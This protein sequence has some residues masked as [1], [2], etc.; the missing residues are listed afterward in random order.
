MTATV[1]STTVPTVIIPALVTAVIPAITVSFLI[2]RNILAFVPVV[3]DKEDPLAAGVVFAT[4]LAPMF[5]VAWGY[6]QIDRLTVH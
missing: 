5:G 6:A 4:V 1:V 2:T 3:V